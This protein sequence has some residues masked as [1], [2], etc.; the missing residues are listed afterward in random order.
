MSQAAV[1]AT[2]ALRANNKFLAEKVVELIDYISN[3]EARIKSLEDNDS[4]AV[5]V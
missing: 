4:W 1:D 2:S 3:L 5:W